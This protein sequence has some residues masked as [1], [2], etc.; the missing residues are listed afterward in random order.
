MMLLHTDDS[1]VYTLKQAQLSP[2]KTFWH[3]AAIAKSSTPV[4]NPD[5]ALNQRNI[6]S[7]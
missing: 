6:S 5:F 4:F 7:A 2:N 3:Q 1:Q